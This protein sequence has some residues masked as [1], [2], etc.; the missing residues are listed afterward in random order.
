MAR[1][2]WNL[3]DK[4][5]VIPGLT[6]EE[7]GELDEKID[8]A[9]ENSLVRKNEVQTDTR[10]GLT[11]WEQTMANMKDRSDKLH[12]SEQQRLDSSHKSNMDARQRRLESMLATEGG[13]YSPITIRRTQE[14]LDRMEGGGI[15]GLRAHE[16]AVA[17]K[18]I[19]Q[20]RVKA[21]GM[22]NQGG[23]A[24]GIKA[25][26][27]QNLGKAQYGYFDE[28]GNY[29]PGST[30]R[31]AEATGLSRTEAE[32]IRGR[33]RLDQIEAQEQGRDR[34]QIQQIDANQKKTDILVDQ[35]RQ[36]REAS[37]EIAGMRIKDVH[38]RRAQQDAMREQRDFEAFDKMVGSVN[39]NLSAAE[40][41]EYKA[42]GPDDRK[43]WWK[44]YVGRDK[45]QTGEGHKD[46]DR[47]QF[48][49]GWATFKNG[50]WIP[51]AQ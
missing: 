12:E 29:V 28:N 49:Q 7:Q 18:G 8:R 6:P 23:V 11:S 22:A 41:N 30:V 40:E 51:D 32:N 50:K 35:K 21:W 44:N 31:A 14:Q 15:P 2:N 10:S 36:D 17:D 4:R 5:P 43:K 24:A 19:E 42:L 33:N 9:N 20:E 13:R 45:E 1:L 27:E 37:K 46:G 25:G 39:S 38:D 3:E 34:R 48:K 26:V 16:L 47:K